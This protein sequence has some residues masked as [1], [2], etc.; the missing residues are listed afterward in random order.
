MSRVDIVAFINSPSTKGGPLTEHY[1]FLKKVRDE[2]NNAGESGI[3][4]DKLGRG[5]PCDYLDEEASTLMAMS[6]CK[7]L[8]QNKRH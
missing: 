3:Y 8:A 5:K 6:Y 2:I 1:D 7:Q 4:I